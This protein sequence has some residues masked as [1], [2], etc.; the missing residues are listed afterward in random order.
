MTEWYDE[1]WKDSP[2]FRKE[3][4]QVGGFYAAYIEPYAG[5]FRLVH[6]SAWSKYRYNGEIKWL[7]INSFK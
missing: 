1:Y 2:V 3:D 4:V 7:P 5:W 6:I